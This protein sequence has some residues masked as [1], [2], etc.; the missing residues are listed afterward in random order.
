M[1]AYIHTR[2]I[3]RERER[4]REDS[5]YGSKGSAMFVRAMPL[6]G[7]G[8]RLASHVFWE[9]DSRY[10]FCMHIRIYISAAGKIYCMKK[11]CA[12]R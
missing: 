12:N 8:A 6:D 2:I 11:R 5:D 9:R 7:L 1:Y 3:E 4:E 10:Q